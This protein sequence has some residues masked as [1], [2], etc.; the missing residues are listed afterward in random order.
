MTKGKTVK[1]RQFHYRQDQDMGGNLKRL[2]A[3]VR[4]LNPSYVQAPKLLAQKNMRAILKRV[5]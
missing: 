4:N 2:Y 1:T 3:Y 5:K